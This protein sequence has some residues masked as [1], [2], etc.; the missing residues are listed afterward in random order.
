M[1]DCLFCKIVAKDLPSTIIYQNPNFLVIRDIKP[2]API[3]LLIITK[4]HI[5]SVDHLA[6]ND[7]ELIGEMVLTAQAVAR[8]QGLRER[9]Y[10]LS[11]N[12]GKGGGQLVPHLHLHLLGGWQ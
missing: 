7:K 11:F 5:P 8:D 6:R 9:G 10:K 1:T 12:V 2:L 3:H 4:K